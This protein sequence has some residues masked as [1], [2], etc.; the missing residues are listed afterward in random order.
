MSNPSIEFLESR[1]FLCGSAVAGTTAAPVAASE[2]ILRIASVTAK[3]LGPSAVEGNYHGDAYLSVGGSTTT[4][5]LKVTIT[6]TSITLRATGY[7]KVSHALTAKQFIELRKGNFKLDATIDGDALTFTG[8]V[9]N[10]GDRIAGSFSAG[11]DTT[12]ITGTFVV[13]KVLS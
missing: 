10:A 2:S 3:I 12:K 11:T 9:T 13:K 1:Q 4:V 5:P 8:T 7:G 6:S